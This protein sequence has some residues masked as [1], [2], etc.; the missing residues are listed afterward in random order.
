[1]TDLSKKKFQI[2]VHF[3]VQEVKDGQMSPFVENT[4]T[5]HDIGYD[6]VVGVE[7]ALMQTL[8]QLNDWGV[9]AAMDAGMGERMSMLGLDAK[10]AALSTAK[11]GS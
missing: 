1:M 9:V 2:K 7:N 6:G 11:T 3:E 8:S 4:L 10:V 5:Y